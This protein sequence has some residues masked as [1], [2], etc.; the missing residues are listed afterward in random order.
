MSFIRCSYSAIKS[1]A[2]E[3]GWC[4]YY[5][6]EIASSHF[7]VYSGDRHTKLMSIAKGADATDFNTNYK[8]DSISVAAEELAFAKINSGVF[9]PFENES[10][11]TTYVDSKVIGCDRAN[12]T[13]TLENKS[14]SIAS[15]YK[16][17]GSANGTDFEEIVG[18]TL[19]ALSSK[20]TVVNNDFWKFIKIQAKSA[21]GTVTFDSYL[22]VGA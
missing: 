17:W 12:K 20:V 21:S 2:N 1:A 7:N 11:G 8:S 18:E 13:F 3:N 5:I 9:R 10:V 15:Y 4:F 22:Q 19:L 14:G 16:I 6:E